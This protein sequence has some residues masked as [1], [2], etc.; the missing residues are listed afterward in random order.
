M[1]IVSEN[2]MKEF[3]QNVID[4]VAQL[5]TQASR[6]DGL[7][8]QVQRLNERLNNLE[9]ENRNLRDQVTDANNTVARMESEINSTKG[10][11]EGER[12]AVS[13][14]RETIFQRDSKLNEVEVYLT[15]ERDAHKITLSERDDARQ[16]I[17]E[18]ESEVERHI[19]HI[20]DLTSDRDTWRSLATDHERELNQVKAQLGQIQSV[21]NPLRVVSSDVA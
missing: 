6:V 10:Q 4:S 14:L 8:E 2:D 17:F 13:A 15:Q 21:L 9:N 12:N 11:L 16:K 19:R 1:S 5:S 3:F 18:L 7:V 20:N